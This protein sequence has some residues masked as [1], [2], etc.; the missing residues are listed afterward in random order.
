MKFRGK[1]NNKSAKNPGP[2][3]IINEFGFGTLG[4]SRREYF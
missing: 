3:K 1:T 4:A 2:Q